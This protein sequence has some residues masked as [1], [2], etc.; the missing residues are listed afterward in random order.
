[1]S[2]VDVA[3]LMLA[4]ALA[5]ALARVIKGPTVADRAIAADVCLYTVV[6]ALSLLSIRLD[7]PVLLDAVL[8]ATMLGFI[9]TVALA[10][11]LRRKR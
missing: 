10:G 6:A 11:L 1:M 2:V 5:M 7:A 9:A 3:L 4:V 8:I